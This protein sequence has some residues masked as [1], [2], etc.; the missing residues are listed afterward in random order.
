M[1]NLALY[2]S[3]FCLISC[4]ENKKSAPFENQTSEKNKAEINKMTEEFDASQKSV[5]L[6]TTTSDL[7]KKIDENDCKDS[8]GLLENIPV[9]LRFFTEHS[10]HE[11]IYVRSPIP[12]HMILEYNDILG[13]FAS[14]KMLERER[15]IYLRIAAKRKTRSQCKQAPSPS[16]VE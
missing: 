11:Y 14:A 16:N 12:I 2:L 10:L 6:Y 9:I 15:V 8:N 1:K 13:N 4:S 5:T 7:A 3:I